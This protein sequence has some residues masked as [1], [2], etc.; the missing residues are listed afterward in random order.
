MRSVTIRICGPILNAIK[1][2]EKENKFID[3][4]NQLKDS[5]EINKIYTLENRC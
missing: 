4:E 1:W 3:C 2:L 5:H